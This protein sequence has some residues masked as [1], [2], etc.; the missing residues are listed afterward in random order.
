MEIERD[1]SRFHHL[2]VMFPRSLHPFNHLFALCV[3]FGIH[4]ST[5]RSWK[6]REI[7]VETDIEEPLI[8]H[9]RV[10]AVFPAGQLVILV[11]EGPTEHCQV[12]T[13]ELMK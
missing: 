13:V 11:A 2:K 3:F 12:V 1:I 7:P 5:E 6:V 10:L 9:V 8:L 4:E